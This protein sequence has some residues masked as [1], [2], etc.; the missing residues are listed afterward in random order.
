MPDIPESGECERLLR[1]KSNMYRHLYLAFLFP[2][3]E[4]IRQNQ[5]PAFFERSLEAGLLGDSLRA[6]VYYTVADRRILRPR[7]N[8]A[9]SKEIEPP[10]RMSRNYYDRLCRSDV[11]PLHEILRHLGNFEMLRQ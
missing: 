8:Q 2:L 5:A 11:I 7:R 4:T 9:P 1:L 3:K 6:C 10:L